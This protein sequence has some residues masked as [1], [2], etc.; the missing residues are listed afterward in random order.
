[1]A[2]ENESNEVDAATV[3][4]RAGDRPDEGTGT[5]LDATDFAL[6]ESTTTDDRQDSM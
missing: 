6:R 3:P 2:S 1:M 4:S 5:G